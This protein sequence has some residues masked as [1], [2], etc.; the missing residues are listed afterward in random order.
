VSDDTVL[1]KISRPKRTVI[2]CIMK[3]LMIWT[4][5]KMQNDEMGGASGT[6]GRAEKC[7]GVWW[8]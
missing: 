5:H 8:R 2:N 7:T 3:S 6:H 1:R 4:P